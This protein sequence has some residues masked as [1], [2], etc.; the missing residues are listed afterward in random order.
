MKDIN[1]FVVKHMLSLR[2]QT[3]K[4]ML[5]NNITMIIKIKL[6]KYKNYKH[7]T[8]NNVIEK[9]KETTLTTTGPL[10]SVQ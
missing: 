7:K 2:Y 9:R 4:H 8:Q 1:E 10:Y 5:Q 6:I 3:L